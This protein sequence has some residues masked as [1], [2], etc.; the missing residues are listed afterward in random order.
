[1]VALLIGDI[2]ALGLMR[3]KFSLDGTF[4]SAIVTLSSSVNGLG[5]E[6]SGRSARALNLKG[7]ASG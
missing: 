5:P 7:S 3:D 6:H 2:E 4:W 1:M